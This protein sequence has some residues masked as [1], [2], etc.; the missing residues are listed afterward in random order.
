M[1]LALRA[2]FNAPGPRLAARRSKDAV[3]APLLLAL[4]K[5]RD[6]ANPTQAVRNEGVRSQLVGDWPVTLTCSSTRRLACL[7]R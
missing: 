5:G 1:P 6:S 7:C 2:D 3:Q 4:A